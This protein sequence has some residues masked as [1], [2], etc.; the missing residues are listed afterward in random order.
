VVVIFG[1]VLPETKRRQIKRVLDG[2]DAL[3]RHKP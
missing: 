3:L 2:Y 1:Q